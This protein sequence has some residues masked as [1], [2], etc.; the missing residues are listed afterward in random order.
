[1]I[2]KRMRIR[3]QDHITKHG[4]KTSNAISNK[5][6]GEEWLEL[7]AF[8]VSHRDH[9]DTD[10]TVDMTVSKRKS[11]KEDGKAALV[12][13]C[14]CRCSCR[15][16]IW[17]GIPCRHILSC[18]RQ[19]GAFHIPQYLFNQ[20]WYKKTAAPNTVVENALLGTCASS[21][22][23]MMIGIEDDKLQ[24]KIN[25]KDIAGER[26]ATLMGIFKNILNKGCDDEKVFDYIKHN[27]INM[28][29]NVLNLCVA[30]AEKQEKRSRAGKSK[31]DSSSVLVLNPA[32]AKTK[33][34][35]PN[36]GARRM[37]RKNSNSTKL[38]PAVKKEYEAVTKKQKQKVAEQ[39]SVVWRTDWLVAGAPLCVRGRV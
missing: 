13:V 29:T 5:K 35:P 34:R 26:Y 10:R 4:D 8:A 20:R 12:E 32:A 17:H 9:P 7:L 30:Q 23:H 24:T 14:S 18:L 1:M 39:I 28:E 25:Q 36:V 2:T 27:L 16:N 21:S 33:G 3:I 38:P 15:K 37:K 31:S 22:G 6:P 19:V 11:E